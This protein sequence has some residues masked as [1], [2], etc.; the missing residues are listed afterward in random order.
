M[1]AFQRFGAADW[2]H[3]HSMLKQSVLLLFA[4]AKQCDAT[5][6]PNRLSRIAASHA[7]IPPRFYAPF[8]E[9]L[10]VTVCGSP[11]GTSA[12]F[13]DE[14]R[15]PEQRQQLTAY[16]RQALKPGIDYLRDRAELARDA[17]DAAA[18]AN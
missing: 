3:Q 12:P 1:P 4:F 14:C 17:R 9:S 7:A 6:E 15:Q 2:Q 10:V 18:L 8:L 13:D 5:V 11:D 16:W